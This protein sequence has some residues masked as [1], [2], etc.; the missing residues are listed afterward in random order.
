QLDGTACDRQYDSV[1]ARRD[2]TVE[3]P[4]DVTERASRCRGRYHTAAHLVADRDD[5]EPG[6]AVGVDDLHESLVDSLLPA[7]FLLPRTE[8]VQYPAQPGAETVD[9]QWRGRGTQ[10]CR[11][12]SALHGVPMGGTASF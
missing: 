11:E 9:Q 5:R 8:F 12:I 1:R 4:Q 6:T 3:A 2:P 10:G 7:R